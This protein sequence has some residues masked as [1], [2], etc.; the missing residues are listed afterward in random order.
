M[1]KKKQTID[2]GTLLE[3]ALIPKGRQ[4]Y[5]VPENWVWTRL[6]NVTTIIGGGTPPSNVLE[7]Y[8]NGS[9]PWISPVDL[10]GYTDIY[11]SQGNWNIKEI[12]KYW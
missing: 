10:S 1:A 9:I 12:T 6:G 11:I 8:A 4:P 3:Q 5:E 2:A 7:Y